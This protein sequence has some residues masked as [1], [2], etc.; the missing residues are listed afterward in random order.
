MPYFYKFTEAREIFQNSNVTN[1]QKDFARPDKHFYHQQ[2]CREVKLWGFNS[3]EYIYYTFIQTG[4]IEK[5]GINERNR[6]IQ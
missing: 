5:Q 2:K 4:I 3:K 1:K 6:K